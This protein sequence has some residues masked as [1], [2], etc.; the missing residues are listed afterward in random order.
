MKVTI[1]FILLIST[2]IT[3]ASE[4]KI[5]TPIKMFEMYCFETNANYKATEKLVNLNKLKRLPPSLESIATPQ[6]GGG[7]GYMVS[8]NKEKKTIYYAWH[9][10]IKQLFNLF[11]R[12]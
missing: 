4:L 5:P 3:N 11:S 9:F 8:G 10:S 7:K 6:T 2:T 12:I 1:F